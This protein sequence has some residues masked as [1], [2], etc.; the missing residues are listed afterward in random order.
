MSPDAEHP[1]SLTLAT[2]VQQAR[3]GDRV[4][5]D[6]LCTPQAVQRWLVIIGLLMPSRL[7]AKVDP[8][9]ILQEA[10]ARAWYDLRNLRE[11]DGPGFYRWVSGIARHV[12]ADVVRSF[13]QQK[14][15]QQREEGFMRGGDSGVFGYSHTPSR[16]VVR[17]E[18]TARVVSLLDE[19]K[20]SYRQVIVYRI[21]EG[22]T[23]QE[24]AARMETTP[25]NVSV[26]LHRA[27][28]KVR[29]LMDTHGLQS[30]IFQI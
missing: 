21:L 18:E 17:R 26:L 29:E 19:L 22:L 13:S 14:R 6:R 23:T 15:D 20:E 11:V 28:V 1:D 25:E 16:S 5:F 4:A 24:A 10:L 8:E 12:S 27:L 7:R 2:W 30:T 3:R 9:D